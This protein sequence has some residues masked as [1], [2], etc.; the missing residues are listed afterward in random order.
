MVYLISYDLRKPGRDYKNLHDAIKTCGNWA[1]PLES[2][3]LIDTTQKAQQI[4]DRIRPHIDENDFLLVTEI[5][6]DRQGWLS[7]EI[8]DWLNGRKAA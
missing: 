4:Y 2:V 3:W 8:W 7:Q 5:G 1:K 6:R